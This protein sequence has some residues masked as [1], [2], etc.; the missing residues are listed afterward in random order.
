M[1]DVESL[2]RSFA[3]WRERLRGGRG[4]LALDLLI[5]A[6]L[7]AFTLPAVRDPDVNGRITTLGTVLLPAVILPILLRHRTPLV[8]AATLAAG[9]VISGIPTFDQFRVGAAVPAAV[10]IAYSVGRRAALRAAVAGL[11]LVL[12]AMVVIGATDVVL[13]DADD[14]GGMLGLVIFTFPLCSGIWV[15]GRLVRSREHIAGQLAERS[16]QLERQREQT[17]A[18]AVEEERARLAS[19]LDA[20]VRTRLRAMID[21]AAGGGAP[22]PAV[23]ARIES[24]GRE[25]LNEM[26]GLLG[27]LRSD[28]RGERSPRPTLAQLDALLAEARTGGSSVT[29]EV[30]GDREPLPTG[31]ELAAYRTVQHALVAVAGTGER[32]VTVRLSY[33]SDAFE[34]EVRGAPA[35]GGVAAAALMA[36]RE[37][38]TAHGGTFST[39]TPVWGQQVLRA[40][41][42][43][44]VTGV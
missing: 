37:R 43:R 27:V 30:E 9:A 4:R 12:A 24:L 20:V 7:L 28:D 32:P 8:A 35:D 2:T 40:W 1:L 11:T 38:V 29:L 13:R 25:A 19:D 21:L 22:A 10:L 14:G 15:A 6:A 26:R 17:A 42:P 18:V 16:L 44:A 23:F 5:C 33:G 34:V 41:L 3:A 39:D 31:L 36:A